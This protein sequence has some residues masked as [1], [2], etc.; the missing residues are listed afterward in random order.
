VQ[1]YNDGAGRIYV[2][3]VPDPTQPL[4]GSWTLLTGLAA[5]A[6]GVCLAPL[7]DRLRLFWQDSATTLIYATDSLDNGGT[8]SA[9]ASLFDA[10][11]AAAGIGAEGA[12]TTVFV[13]YAAAANT[14]RVAAWTLAG[15]WSK[16]DWTLGNSY[17]AAGLGVYNVSRTGTY[18]L[19]A[20][21]LQ[22]TASTGT[23]LSAA[24]Y[25]GGT[26]SVL[27]TVVPA[28]L[29]A[30]LALQDPRVTAYDGLYHLS[31]GVVDSGSTSG[32]TSARVAVAHSA[33]GVHWA[34][35]LEDGNS[36][37]HGAVA[38]KHN[39]GYVLAA[40]DVSALAPLYTDSAAQYRDCT[41]DVS[42]LEV[43]QK[44]GAPARLTVT[45]Q[46]DAG[47]YTH[48]SA[49]RPNARL[50][51][52]LGYAGAGTV[53]THVCYVE[54]WTFMRAADE[55]SVVV[56]AGDARAW[57][58]RQSRSTL[59]YTNQTLDWLT[60]EVLARA[61]LLTVTLPATSQF[62]QV[63]P[64]F[65]IPGG[66]TWL[67]ALER[68]A[69]L[70]GYDVAARAQAGGTDMIV[71]VEKAP[72]DAAV[73]SYG[74]ELEG[75]EVGHSGDRA[76]HVL[77]YGQPGPTAIVG[78]AWDFGDAGG[79]GQERYLHAVEPLITTRT[80]AGIRASLELNAE[81]RRALAGRLAGALHP[82]L[83]LWDVVSCADGVLG[84]TTA[85]VA[86]LHHIYEPFTGRYDLVAELEGV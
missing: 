84:S 51:L 52:S 13:L 27:T 4:W 19:V 6:A 54:E 23:A 59:S 85:R 14:Y 45:L 12:S 83:E 68:L 1:A 80:G 67:L 81:K 29:A 9:P 24:F 66:A 3:R 8:W 30:G 64:T 39:A 74:D 44:D 78:E 10:G 62:S 70:Y 36:Y 61:G 37:A 63:V 34:D 38:L 21:A 40:P 35:P 41:A 73:W 58:A 22:A 49:L 7:S 86:A 33:D 46:N 56:V 65:A 32:L 75:L 26:W 47:Q 79:V 60:R 69:R 16:A 28:D 43:Q 48:L 77:V 76:N 15:T 82:G 2:R 5:A 31:Y 42:R 17:G 71:V 18:Y 20:A 53:Y 72:A 11:G 55:S 25:N 50:R 57:L